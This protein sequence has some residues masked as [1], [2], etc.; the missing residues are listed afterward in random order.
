MKRR[1]PSNRRASKSRNRG[2]SVEKSQTCKFEI[3][4][5]VTEEVQDERYNPAAYGLG[6]DFKAESSSFSPERNPDRLSMQ[7]AKE[8][9][10][11]AILAYQ[12]QSP[13]DLHSAKKTSENKKRS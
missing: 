2:N 10:D 13:R 9:A 12:T 7:M 3:N 5:E 11:L 4:L 8:Q 1:S 6:H